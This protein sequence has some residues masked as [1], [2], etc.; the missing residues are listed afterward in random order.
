MEKLSSGYIKETAKGGI[1]VSIGLFFSKIIKFLF[2][3][4]L[5][6]FLGAS[7]YGIYSLG[8]SIIG[9]MHNFSLFGLHNG[10]VKFG[11]IYKSRKDFSRL[12]S[13]VIIALIISL[14]ISAVWFLFIYFG[15]GFLAN[16]VFN[17]P[18]LAYVLKIFAYS[19]PCLVIITIAASYARSFRKMLYF[20]GLFDVFHP[21][22][23][24][25]LVAILLLLGL[26]L[27]GAVNGF[28]VASVISALV[29][30]F[31]IL[32][33][34]PA[35]SKKDIGFS[36][37]EIRKLMSFSFIT[38][39]V[40]LAIFLL[41]RSDSIVL[42]YFRSASDVGVYSAAA[43]LAI[44]TIIFVNAFTVIFAPL[45]LDIH[46]QG[47]HEEVKNIFQIITRWCLTLS[48]PLLLF[49]IFFSS[50]LMNIF[51]EEFRR[52]GT[53]LII[54][55]VAQLFCIIG[56]GATQILLMLGHHKLESINS[57]EL[58]I[59]NISLN[60][61]LISKFGIMGAAIAT[62]LAFLAINSLRLVQIYFIF[63][64]SP[65]TREYTKF[66]SASIGT[67]ILYTIIRN[68]FP[69]YNYSWII[70]IP[71]I[72]GIYILILIKLGFDKN[73][74]LVLSAIKQKI[75]G[76]KLNKTDGFI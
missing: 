16:K 75:M 6:R 15:G 9:I 35:S 31:I 57:V 74:S 36:A 38:L 46:H 62:T 48:A 11:S 5:T 51:G 33:L 61:I 67:V 3:V 70:G 20:T 4:L 37:P 69:S 59:L 64:F 50:Q 55:C 60:I 22:L 8:Y 68:I 49:V 7:S 58:I 73:D 39:F 10:I 65:F 44:Q 25:I 52:G 40:D 41:F 17:K 53:V 26:H 14:A 18:D 2:H 34:L 32:K 29:G 63:G 54:L 13:V 72:F 24:F 71:I 43:N 21:F 12:R 27:K 28:L 56:T 66:L 45:I 30:I 76:V 1:I 42:G 47:K 19:L 23:I